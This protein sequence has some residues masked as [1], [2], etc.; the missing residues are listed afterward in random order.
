MERRKKQK[1]KE[2]LETENKLR[3]KE[4]KSYII[5]KQDR[6]KV[7]KNLKINYLEWEEE[8]TG[9]CKRKGQKKFKIRKIQAK[10]R[11]KRMNKEIKKK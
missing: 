1:N 7:K 8:K 3:N 5:R 10:G 6:Q 4:K 11:K 2:I 9:K